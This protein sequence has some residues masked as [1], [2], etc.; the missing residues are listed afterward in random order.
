MGLAFDTTT[1]TLYAINH[2]RYSG[3][4]IESFNVSVSSHTLT[5]VQTL[6]HP[7][8][9]TP[10]AIQL[11]S[12]G[13]MYVTNEHYIRAADSFILSQIETFGAIPGGNV[14]YVD[15]TT[16][17]VKLL[18]RLPFA[19]GI[20]KLND[21]TLVVASSST[22]GLYFY[23]IAP[24][25]IGLKLVNIIRTPAGPDNL[26]VDGKGKVLIAGHPY[27]PEIEEVA[28]GR[29]ECHEN[30]TEEQRKKCTCWAP[31]WVGEWSE[32]G[33][34]KTLLKDSGKGENGICSSSTA[35]R[36]VRKGVGMVTM[37]YG[38]GL[39]MFRE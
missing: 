25:G 31:S 39:V 8:I 21:T 9:H 27:A 34:L 16:S 29:G 6:K 1:S 18:A 19:N 26:S 24:D 20:V 35:V 28:H 15:T 5:H 10:N 23:S 30:G 33:G 11:L 12:N 36:D 17:D 3:S 4:N 38:K 37:L 14:V 13:K 7:L 32:E 22:P 2:S